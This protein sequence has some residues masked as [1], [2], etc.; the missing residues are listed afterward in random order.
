MTPMR[1]RLS[2]AEVPNSDP[3]FWARRLREHRIKVISA[4]PS[5]MD[6]EGKVA[7]I[8]KALGTKIQKVADARTQFS[9]LSV[10]EPGK[11]PPLAY[12]PREP[13]FFG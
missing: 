5:G 8:E 9:E 12:V 13:T 11:R 10:R 7:D 1:F 6:A 2:F 3:D 4:K